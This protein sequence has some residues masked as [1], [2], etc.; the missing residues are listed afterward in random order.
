MKPAKVD[1]PTIWRGCDYAAIIF[2]W[3]DN[4]GQP[5][6]LSGWIAHA[7]TKQINFAP[8]ITDPVHGIAQI[9][10]TRAETANLKLGT[11]NWDWIFTFGAAATPPLLAGSVQI[12]EPVTQAVP[13]SG[14]LPPG[15]LPPGSN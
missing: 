2:R 10:L 14:P 1:L 6:N 13:G 5:Y 11:E 12:K 8:V 3:L 7:T 9:S 15:P 4:N